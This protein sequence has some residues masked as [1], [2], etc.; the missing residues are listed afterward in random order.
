MTEIEKRQKVIDEIARKSRNGEDLRAL[1][2]IR[3]K[4]LDCAAGSALEVRLCP[5]TDCP[6]WA[7]RGGHYPKDTE[8]TPQD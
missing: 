4:C 3:M 7:L 1:K 5:C 2:R 6:L 8:E